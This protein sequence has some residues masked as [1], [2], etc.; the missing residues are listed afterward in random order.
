MSA[1]WIQ[2]FR[3]SAISD[4]LT[5]ANV[6]WVEGPPAV[7]EFL[8][9]TI[10]RRQKVQSYI[11]ASNRRK[12]NDYKFL[13]AG[14]WIA[15]GITLDGEIG[16]IPYLKPSKPRTDERRKNRVIKYETP[17]DLEAR[18][19]LPDIS[20]KIPDG[21]AGVIESDKV[22]LLLEGLKK[23]LSAIEEGF[24]AVGLRGVFNWHPAGSK[25]LWPELAAL[26]KGRIVAVAFDQDEKL[27]TRST[28][29]RQ[30]LLMGN[31]IE[32]A[33]GTPVFLQWDGTQG[34]GLDDVLASL[35]PGLRSH[36]LESR[37]S[38]ALTLQKFRRIQTTAQAE[39]ILATDGPPADRETTGE[40]L[41]ELPPLQRG[42]INALAATMNSGKTHRMGR[43]WV[44]PWAAMGGITVVLSPLNSLG[45]QTAG[46]IDENGEKYGWDIPH[47]HD[48]FTDADSQQALMA[49]IRHRGGLVACLNSAPRVLSLIPQDAP[50]LLIFDEAAQTLTDAAEGGTLKNE[51]AA[52][53]EDTIALMQR[54]VGNGAIALAEAG[55]DQA[56]IDLVKALSGT[57]KV[58]VIRHKKKLEPWPC[59][60]FGG[61]PLSGFRGQLLSA[62]QSGKRLMMV[63]TSQKEAR[64]VER[65]AQQLGIDS[66]RID[67]TTNEGERYREFFKAP[68][69][70]LYKRM[71]QLLILTTSGKT[72][73]S[74]EGKVTADDAYFDEV[75]GY[76]PSLDTDT[77]MQLLGRYRPAVPR[78]IWAPAFIQPEPGEGPKVWGIQQDLEKVAAQYATYGKFEQSAQDAHDQAI[79]KY[80]AIRRQRRWA[81]KM[82]PDEALATALLNA[83]H[84]M[85][86]PSEEE[87]AGDK[88]TAKIWDEIKEQLAREDGDYHAALE[89]DPD[90]HTWD[91]ANKVVRGIDSTYEQRCK[92]AK[93]RMMG[94]F[95]GLD[96][97]DAQLWYDAAFC[98][99]RAE[100]NDRP[101]SGPLAPGAALWAEAGHYNA[102]WAEDSKEAA[103]VLG[104][105]LKAAH[106]LPTNGTRAM[107]AG[108]FRPLIETLLAAGQVTPGGET[109]QVIKAKALK[110]RSELKRFWRL[111]V[112]ESQSDVAISNKIARK[113]GLVISRFKKTT[114]Q[115]SQAWICKIAET[116]TWRALV[117]AREYAL[118]G[119]TNS[120]ESAFNKF[121]PT[122]PPDPPNSPPS[123]ERRAAGQGSPGKNFH[124]SEG[125]AA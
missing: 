122:S 92:A 86:P 87:C 119:G 88:E 43:D 118:S 121:V 6:R 8:A 70:W 3:A 125:S 61:T 21:W 37:I 56:T 33:G 41:P 54:A 115:G 13:E 112:D 26:V 27:K 34:K 102:L 52:R 80:L 107:L 84:K 105:R 90:T 44:W 82:Q 103:Q 10:A 72:G 101:S 48:Y 55:L 65:A 39:A 78:I 66:E 95:P 93:V 99:R 79:K 111:Q 96:W 57:S 71:P 124:K 20:P 49:D 16:E 29:T 68:E 123:V 76:F 40:Y 17:P 32:R 30:A 24:P 120:L 116:T 59:K 36:W 97:N 23:A 100:T 85:T 62:L 60:I 67:S 69:K 28:V 94:R 77:H 64:R 42:G 47:I 81:Q 73:L 117:A 50:L 83:G 75:W 108:A 74:I 38:S 91:W 14:G 89:I 31:A 7:D 9:E 109:E 106:L 2:E 11:T 46:G 12:M 53:W 15:Y 35:P 98:P 58:Q 51:W 63:T 18:P 19:L 1:P 110:L 25:D 113:F 4:E 45:K 104:Q 5:L 114:Y 22:I